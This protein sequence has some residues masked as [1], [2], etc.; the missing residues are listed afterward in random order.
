MQTI[1]TRV[2]HKQ[3][4]LDNYRDGIVR[5]GWF[6]GIR[7]EDGL[8]VAQVAYWNEYGVPNAK[9]PIPARPFMRPVMHAQQNDL[10]ERLRSLYMAAIRNNTNTLNAL[11]TFGELVLYKIQDQIHANIYTPNAPITL[12][13][14]WLR[15]SSG[16]SFHVERKRGSHPLID[17]GFMVNSITYQI[18]EVKV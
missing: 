17:T 2:S 15:S 9:Y 10:K 1:S 14:G 18:E 3:I 8:P 4:N 16:K 12:H 13:G 7:Y 5:V 6:S 11:A